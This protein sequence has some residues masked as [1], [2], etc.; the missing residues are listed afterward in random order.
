MPNHNPRIAI[1]TAMFPPAYL[2]GGPIRTLDALVRGAPEGFETAVITADTDHDQ[3]KPLDVISDDWVDY[4]GNSRVYYTTSRSIRALWRAML[5]AREFKPDVVYVNSF[6]GFHYSIIPQLLA[7]AGFFGPALLLIAPRGEFS[8]SALGLKTRK[9]LSFVRLYLLLRMN[10]VAIWHAS[11]DVEAED[12]RAVMGENIEVI[13]K[14]DDTDLVSTRTGVARSRQHGPLQAAT[15]SRLVPIKRVD[16]LLTALSMVR[17]PMSLHVYGPAEDHAYSE[18]CY[19]IG[20]A[21]PEHI[22]VAFHGEVEHDQIRRV[23]AQHDVMLLPTASENFGHV[24]AEALSV[25]C[26]VICADTTPWTKWLRAGGGEIVE[27]DIVASW[28][29]VI[30]AYASL[31]PKQLSERREGAATAFDAW[32]LASASM[33]HLFTQLKQRLVR[34]D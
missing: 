7:R 5:R 8:R 30:D 1:F 28:A 26:P 11:S 33:P 29:E 20:R 13:V 15:V 9:K 4:A 19:A 16:M 34:L 21:L 23:L 6:F 18:R 17:T 31:R 22:K 3:I 10:R 32:Q 14:E 27:P 25:S 24:V 12:I 2:G